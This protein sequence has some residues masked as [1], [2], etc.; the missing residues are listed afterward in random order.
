MTVK[1]ILLLLLITINLGCSIKKETVIPDFDLSQPI[2]FTEDSSGY[3]LSFEYLNSEIGDDFLEAFDDDEIQKKWDEFRAGYESQFNEILKTNPNGQ[4]ID[5]YQEKDDI[6]TGIIY[7][8][9]FRLIR[10]KESDEGESVIVTY[11]DEGLSNGLQLSCYNDKGVAVIKFH[12]TNRDEAKEAYIKL[13]I[14]MDM[15]SPISEE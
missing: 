7:N 13:Y 5:V 10:G 6:A 3:L 9:I 15:L 4:I 14:L 12:F 11:F 2:N 1:Y 8:D